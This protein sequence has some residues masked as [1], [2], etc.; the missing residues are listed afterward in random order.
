MHKLVLL[1]L[2]STVSKSLWLGLSHSFCPPPFQGP[3]KA[4]CSAEVGGPGSW[5]RCGSEAWE[6]S[7]R[8]GPADGVPGHSPHSELYG[9]SSWT[10]VHSGNMPKAWSRPPRPRHPTLHSALTGLPAPLLA[11]LIKSFHPLYW[12]FNPLPFPLC[13]FHQLAW[14][15]IFPITD[16]TLAIISSD[17]F[18]IKTHS[19]FTQVFSPW[20]V[21]G[22]L[23][24]YI[25]SDKTSHTW[26]YHAH[27]VLPQ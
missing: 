20:M 11:I 25:L 3:F 6:L 16:K 21:R 4:E 26:H 2:V 27:Y 5:W 10:S 18:L 7:V 12:L 8:R 13:L 15:L 17:N 22:P 19:F 14:I 9:E 23:D 1:C 24:K